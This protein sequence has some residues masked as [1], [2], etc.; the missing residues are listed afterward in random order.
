MN[1]I[2]QGS[3]AYRIL[4]L[5]VFL[6][7]LFIPNSAFPILISAEGVEPLEGKTAASVRDIALSNALMMAIEKAAEQI[8]PNLDDKL[9]QKLKSKG[10]LKYVKSY[11]ILDET[12]VGEGYRISVEANV[13]SEG[14]KNRLGDLAGVSTKPL[15]R[16]SSISIVVLQSPQSDPIIK[17][18][19]LADIKREI[20]TALIGSG[21]KIVEPLG[22]IRL[23]AYVSLKT[24]ESKIGGATTYYALG[25]VFIRVEDKDGKVVTEVSESSYSS[26]PDLR[27]IGLE[28]IR[29]AGAKA[30]EK[31]KSEFDKRW[32]NTGSA[33]SSIGWGNKNGTIEISFNDLGS[34][35][36]Y[37]QINNALLAAPEIKGIAERIFRYKGVSFLVISRTNTDE[38]AKTLRKLALRGFSLKLNNTSSYGIEFSLVE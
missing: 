2:R 37:E 8:N 27:L 12:A 14:L 25:S 36:Q 29:D 33:V 11:R 18:L 15:G 26:G 28:V 3:R 30:A 23:Q 21:Y 34:Y 10:P 1:F 32:G 31:L 7:L 4:C 17:D 38:L 20:S 6:I 9:I 22:D 35:S 13:D 24:T 5:S 16:P 19:S